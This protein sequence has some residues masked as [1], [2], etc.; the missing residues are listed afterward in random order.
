MTLREFIKN[1]FLN[2]ET[3]NTLGYLAQH[4]LFDQ[5]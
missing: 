3:N 5:V 1:Y 2:E 4:N